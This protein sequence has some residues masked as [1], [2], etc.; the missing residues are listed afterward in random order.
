M[1]KIEFK[2]N[3]RWFTLVATERTLAKLVLNELAG[4]EIK[5]GKRKPN[6]AKQTA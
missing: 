3:N 6:F 2:V 5:W 1:F 4:V